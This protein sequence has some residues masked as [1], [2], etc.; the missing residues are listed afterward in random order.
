[1]LGPR[2]PGSLA[3]VFRAWKCRCCRDVTVSKRF[4][5]EGTLAITRTDLNKQLFVFLLPEK[6]YFGSCFETRM[7]GGSVCSLFLADTGSCRGR[8]KR[9]LL[10][11]QHCCKA[12]TS[13]DPEW[14]AHDVEYKDYLCF[15]FFFFFCPP[16]PSAAPAASPE[17]A[18]SSAPFCGFAP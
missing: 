5:I 6:Q 9:A 14:F 12:L 15:G 1:M 18:G 17:L 4:V 3:K 8:F 16:N 13:T 10:P 7:S 2:Q 11:L